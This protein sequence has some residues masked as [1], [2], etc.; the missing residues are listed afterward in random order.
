MSPRLF[1]H[2]ASM[3][4]RRAMS[5]RIDFWIH[6]VVGFLTELALA[7]FLWAGMFAGMSAAAMGVAVIGG[8]TFEGLVRYAVLV[9]L[10]G[11]VVRGNDLEG[12]IAQEIYDG[13]LSR[14]RVYPV[15]HYL[16]KYAQHVGSLLPGVVQLLL[17]GAAWVLLQGGSGLEGITPLGVLGFVAALVLGNVLQFALAWPI[18]GVAFWAENVWSLMV[19]L[20]FVAGLLGGSMLPLSV[21][22]EAVRPW[23]D[24][25]PF[26]YLYAFPVEVLTGLV[27]GAGFVRGAAICL[28]WVVGLRLLGVY[29]W[30]RGDRIY[31]GAGM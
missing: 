22:P 23:L 17:F 2:V 19:A 3:S 26:R 12:A 28:A 4:A 25:L 9:A 13:S 29:V 16:F 20:R 15:S 11:K 5:Y 18:Q 8:L 27:D 30:R 21:F 1:L 24:A 10:V 6:A 31:S 14:Y 7:W